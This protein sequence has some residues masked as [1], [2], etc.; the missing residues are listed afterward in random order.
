MK[1]DPRANYV[2]IYEECF[3]LPNVKH[4]RKGNTDRRKSKRWYFSLLLLTMGLNC[5]RI[6][7]FCVLKTLTSSCPQRIPE[8]A[9]YHP[10]LKCSS[11]QRTFIQRAKSVL[12]YHEERQILHSRYPWGWDQLSYPWSLERTWCRFSRPCRAILAWVEKSPVLFEEAFSP[13][14][15]RS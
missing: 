1:A 5:F 4:I 13:G 12:V 6:H 8:V 7:F 3:G 15:S 14:S 10:Q 11:I 2:K 9:V